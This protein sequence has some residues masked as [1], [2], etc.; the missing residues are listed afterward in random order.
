M[1]RTEESKIN[2][3]WIF[4][5]EWNENTV[6]MC[7]HQCRHSNGLL[8]QKTHLLTIT[9][10]PGIRIRE[11]CIVYTIDVGDDRYTP[12][13]KD[14]HRVYVYRYR[15]A[16]HMGVQNNQDLFL[17]S[18]KIYWIEKHNSRRDRMLQLATRAPTTKQN[19]CQ[20]YI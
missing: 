7:Q 18:C 4:H 13:P 3:R 9:I 6:I 8:Q 15:V 5:S 2:F 16:M 14:T 19:L 12:V 20:K 17:W 11:L 10:Q 1:C